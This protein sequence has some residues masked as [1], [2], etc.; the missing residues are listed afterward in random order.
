MSINVTFP[1]LMQWPYFFYIEISSYYKIQESNVFFEI[2]TSS[3]YMFTMLVGLLSDLL[4]YK[5]NVLVFFMIIR[6]I[7]Y[8]FSSYNILAPVIHKY[9]S[10]NILINAIKHFLIANRPFSNYK[11]NIKNIIKKKGGWGLVVVWMF[12]PSN[13]DQQ[14][15]V[16]FNACMCSSCRISA[17][18]WL[19][20]NYKQLNGAPRDHKKNT[21]LPGLTNTKDPPSIQSQPLSSVSNELK[22]YL[23]LLFDFY[24]C[25]CFCLTFILEGHIN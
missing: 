16:P 12:E 2:K 8:Y 5:I 21:E 10:L 24:C 17:I 20:I 9:A 7:S 4:T 23:C 22:W 14:D 13:R 1:Q 3:R 15:V 25:C 18:S 11:L 19:L 6:R